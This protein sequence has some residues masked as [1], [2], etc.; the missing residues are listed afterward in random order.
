M[1]WKN[2][3]SVYDPD[4]PDFLAMQHA[5]DIHYGLRKIEEWDEEYQEFITYKKLFPRSWL[6]RI[7][8]RLYYKIFYRRNYYGIK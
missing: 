8:R 7:I 3:T 6:G 1:I 2:Y 4:D 5:I